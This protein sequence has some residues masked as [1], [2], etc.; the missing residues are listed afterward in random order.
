M[1]ILSC[2]WELNPLNLSV[3][4]EISREE[5]IL[6]TKPDTV[7][8]QTSG[9]LSRAKKY[10]PVTNKR[11]KVTWRRLLATAIFLVVVVA[12]IVFGFKYHNVQNRANELSSNP[13]AAAVAAVTQVTNEVGKLVALPAN[14]TPTLATVNDVTKLKGQTFFANA[15]NG[16][17]VLIY[18]Q[19]KIA[20]LYRPSI[21]KVINIAPL[22]IGNG[23]ATTGSKTGQ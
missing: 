17:K 18:T 12:A 8:E 15:Q 7:N 10:N 16:D 1:H 14:E 11:G 4:S 5:S 22:N 6:A 3:I 20:V 13:Q 9:L 2:F 21:D 19:A 23:T